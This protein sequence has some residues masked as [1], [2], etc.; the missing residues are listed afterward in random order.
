MSFATNKTPAEAFTPPGEKK[1]GT[2][3]SFVKKRKR[4]PG[5]YFFGDL[6]MLFTSPLIKTLCHYTVNWSKL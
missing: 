1:M 6:K 2:R 5:L 3:W 4:V